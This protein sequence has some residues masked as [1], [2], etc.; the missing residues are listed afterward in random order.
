MSDPIILI[1]GGNSGIG[2]AAAIKFA[3]QGAK[4]LI[5]VRNPERGKEAISDIRKK[6]ESN[7]SSMLTMDLSSMNSIRAACEEFQKTN[8]RLDCLIH[9]AADFDIGRKMP[10]YSED[11]IEKIWA[12]NHLGP[13]RLTKLLEK[14]LA[15]SDK[16]RIITIASKGLMV[17]PF[18]KVRMD[19]PEFKKGGYSVEKAYYQ[20]KLA[21]IM[22]T[23]WLAEKYQKTSITANCIRVTNVRI[24]I[25]RY[26]NIS[27][28]AK[29]LYAWKSKYSISP[30]QMAEVY[31]WLAT[32]PEARKYSGEYFDEKCRKVSSGKYSKDPKNI[33]ELMEITG[34]YI[35]ELLLEK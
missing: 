34:K 21:Q 19:D 30:P 31:V 2:K 27:P 17:H 16:G 18:L 12:T 35:P 9:N 6:S 13:V 5:A 7:T 28:I 33:H 29:K 4:V 1:T 25:S 22:Y 15:R 24:D 11:G 8:T 10:E 26:P 14:E 20:S 32:S 23:Y 3:S